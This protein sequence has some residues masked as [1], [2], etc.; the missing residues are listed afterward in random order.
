MFD[1]EADQKIQDGMKYQSKYISIVIRNAMEDFHT[2]HLSDEQ[3]KE[4]NPLIRNAVYTALYTMQYYE[5]SLRLRE[6][7]GSQ[8]E[9]IPGYWEEPELIGGVGEQVATLAKLST[10]KVHI[11]ILLQHSILLF[12]D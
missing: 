12:L 11:I 2:K 7:V 8:V 3:M 10:P 1:T 5:D 9:M 6:F 4:L